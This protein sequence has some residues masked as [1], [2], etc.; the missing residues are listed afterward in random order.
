M[1][2]KIL[3]VVV[4]LLAYAAL[5]PHAAEFVGNAVDR[6]MAYNSGRVK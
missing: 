3:I 1:V 6:E 4:A 2:K 5:L